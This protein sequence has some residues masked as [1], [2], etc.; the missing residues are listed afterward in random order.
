MSTF[1][2]VVVLSLVSLSVVAV[3]VAAPKEEETKPPPRPPIKTDVARM[4]RTVAHTIPKRLKRS[5]HDVRRFACRAASNKSDQL[6]AETS[7]HSSP[8]LALGEYVLM[9][10]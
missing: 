8:T 2:A 7:C 3:P 1:R 4:V 5:P 10:A 6:L 9:L